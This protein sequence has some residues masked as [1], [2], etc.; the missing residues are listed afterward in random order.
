M[1][2]LQNKAWDKCLQILMGINEVLT[3]KVRDQQLLL[4]KHPPPEQAQSPTNNPLEPYNAYSDRSRYGGEFEE[5]PANNAQS[6]PPQ[7]A[8]VDGRPA[9]TQSA[10]REP[11]PPVPVTSKAEMMEQVERDPVREGDI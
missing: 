10:F 9:Q 4:E 7:T 5:Q 1:I 6:F 3:A 8:A 11:P 2:E